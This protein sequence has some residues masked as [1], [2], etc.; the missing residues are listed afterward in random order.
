M[1]LA[2][3]LPSRFWRWRRRFG[4]NLT[5]CNSLRTAKTH[6]QL[7]VDL[8][9]APPPRLRGGAE[10]APMRLR[11]SPPSSR[12]FGGDDGVLDGTA[13]FA[14]ACG[15][16]KPTANWRWTWRSRRRQKPL[17]PASRTKDC[18][19]QTLFIENVDGTFLC[20]EGKLKSR[21]GLRCGRAKAQRSHR[22]LRPDGT[23]AKSGNDR[24]Q[25]EAESTP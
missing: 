15:P 23:S 22:S 25:R 24:H 18:S 10:S 7:A 13:Y 21:S 12:F 2:S 6:R 14:I 11:A 20:A 5:S 17:A 9:V 1:R 4:R 3:S 16:P 8:A 19:A